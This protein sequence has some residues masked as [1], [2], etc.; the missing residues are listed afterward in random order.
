MR[1]LSWAA[2]LRAMHIAHSNP[3]MRMNRVRTA[4][5]PPNPR[6]ETP[7]PKHLLLVDLVTQLLGHFPRNP[8]VGDLLERDLFAGELAEHLQ[9]FNDLLHAF[10]TR[11]T[12][13]RRGPAI[14]GEHFFRYLA[15][16]PN[17]AHD[18]IDRLFLR[19]QQSSLGE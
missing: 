5:S 2:E 19:L 18:E 14:V 13:T 6:P 11:H 7:D 4:I 9:R 3:H 12:I 17:C 1:I 16:D 10:A 15:I 8:G